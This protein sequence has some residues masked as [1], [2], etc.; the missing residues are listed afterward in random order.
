M[1]GQMLQ[2]KRDPFTYPQYNCCGGNDLVAGIPIFNLF[3]PQR[4]Y[5]KDFCTEIEQIYPM[6]NKESEI[7]G[8]LV[9]LYGD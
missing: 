6:R 1:V 4:I 5:L 3:L 8:G 2:G 9:Y 7:V